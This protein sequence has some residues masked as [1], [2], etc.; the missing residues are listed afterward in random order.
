M[1]QYGQYIRTVAH[2]LQLQWWISH[3]S[4]L[5][6]CREFAHLSYVFDILMLTQSPLMIIYWRRS[7]QLDHP[8]PFFSAT[9]GRRNISQVRSQGAFLGAQSALV[10]FHHYVVLKVVAAVDPQ[11]APPRITWNHC[12]GDPY[13]LIWPAKQWS[14]RQKWQSGNWSKPVKKYK[15]G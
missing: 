3:C 8:S 9:R 5:E 14:S 4:D 15:T 1:A 12:I 2:V 11:S 7:P 13:C 10:E 6:F